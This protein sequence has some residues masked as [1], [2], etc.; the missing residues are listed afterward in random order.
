MSLI[1]ED[2]KRKPF[3]DVW[4][5]LREENPG[6]RLV[7]VG[8]GNLLGIRHRYFH[9]DYDSSFTVRSRLAIFDV[10]NKYRRWTEPKTRIRLG[11]DELS[12]RQVVFSLME[13]SSD[14][15][16]MITSNS[17]TRKGQEGNGFAS[18]LFRLSQEQIYLVLR[19]YSDIIGAR[20]VIAQLTDGSYGQTKDVERKGWSTRMAEQYGYSF[21][22]RVNDN[23]VFQKDFSVSDCQRVYAEH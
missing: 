6:Q 1:V 13:G 16:V 5:T 17:A 15:P 12:V 21:V 7:R 4:S 2:P 19:A 10:H 20:R 22:E 3:L 11:V 14:L 8:A 9:E 23:S 18:V